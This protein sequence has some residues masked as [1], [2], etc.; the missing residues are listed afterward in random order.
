MI[1]E[2]LDTR[3]LLNQIPKDIGKGGAVYIHNGNAAITTI[4]RFRSDN[5]TLV[6]DFTLA[7]GA[8]VIV[9][10]DS[11][12]KLTSSQTSGVTATKTGFRL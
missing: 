11:T 8:S 1:V 5:S 3:Q 10:K 4:N 6:G 7:A 9:R 2:P 12:D